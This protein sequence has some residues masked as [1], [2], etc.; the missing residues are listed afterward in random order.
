MSTARRT[1][2]ILS[3]YCT[4]AIVA[5]TVGLYSYDHYR[6]VRSPVMKEQYSYRGDDYPREWD[7]PALSQ[8]LMN[9]ENSVHYSLNTS[10]SS[11]EWAA[12]LPNQGIIY[13]GHDRHN[14]QPFTTSLFH[15]LR[16]LNIIRQQ[17]VSFRSSDPKHRQEPSR[18]ASHCM[19]YLRQMVLCRS[20]LHLESVRSHV[21]PRVAVSDVTRRCKDWKAVY[22][23]A[24]SNQRQY[25]ERQSY[26]T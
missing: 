21:G 3:T 8:V 1:I 19:N 10:L 9:M 13:L 18:L 5:F 23:A 25:Q 24:E 7:I 20:N 6:N 17:I 4:L 22:D 12:L 2:V 15:Q 14:P 16:C 26:G 11:Q